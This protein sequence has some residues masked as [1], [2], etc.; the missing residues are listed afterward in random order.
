M[1]KW[2]GKYK[3]DNGKSLFFVSFK[4]MQFIFFK[5]VQK[6]ELEFLLIIYYFFDN[7]FC[8]WK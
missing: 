5:G 8:V 1:N 7:S 3:F 4:I 6:L 2:K